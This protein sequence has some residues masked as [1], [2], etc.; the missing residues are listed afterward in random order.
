MPIYSPTGFLDITNATLR[1]SNTECQNLQIGSGNVYV[2]TDLTSNLVL[3]LENITNLGATTSNTVVFSNVTTGLTVSSNIV[4]TGNVTAGSFLGDGSGLTAV[5]AAQITGTLDAARIPALDTAKITTGTL[6]AAR[7]PA[8]DTAKITTGTLDAARIPALDT[9]KI[10]TGTLDAAR[11]PALDTAK[12]TTGTL[13]VARIPALDTAK[14]TTGTLD[15]ARIP[16]LDTAKITTGTLD[17]ARI[18]TLNQNTSGSAAT[19]TTA[20]TIG[21]VSFD[22]SAAIVP[23][24][25][26]TATFSGD[27]TVD[28][29]TFHV[30]STNNRVG[31]G[32]T[33]PVTPLEVSQPSGYF[34]SM[35]IQKYLGVGPELATSYVLLLK[36]ESSSPKRLAGK[37]QGVRGYSSINTAFEAEI[38]AGVGSGAAL[39][40]RMTLNYS[41]TTNSFYAKLVSLTYSSSTYIALALIPTANYNGMSGGI[42]FD[43]KTNAI[44]ELQ[45]ITD[46]ATLSNIVDFPISGGDKTTF[47]GNVGVGTVSP[48]YK[49]NILTDTN[50]D[51]ISLRDSTRELMK[52]AKGTDG[53]YINM[54]ESGVS[55]VNIAT[56]GDSYFIGGNVGIGTNAPAHKLHLHNDDEFVYHRWSTTA[57]GVTDIFDI[58]QWNSTR[59]NGD[60]GVMFINRAN[61][62]M[63]FITNNAERMRIKNDGDIGIGTDSPN[64]LLDILGPMDEGQHKL[65]L[66]D[67]NTNLTFRLGLKA[68]TSGYQNGWTTID[69]NGGG[70]LAI[71]DVVYVAGTLSVSSTKNFLIDHPLQPTTKKLIHT[72]VESPRVD[73]IY[74][75]TTQ[76]KDGRAIVNIDRQCVGDESCAMEDGTFEALCR[77]PVYYLQNT[78]DFNRLI[79]TID[80]NLLTIISEDVN[81]IAIVNWMVV[82]ERK[83]RDI[84]EATQTNDNGRLN[85]EIIDTSERVNRDGSARYSSA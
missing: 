54:F 24:T 5:P 80:K 59:S 51:G 10:T 52:I 17:A 4:A 62:D 32:T 15:A 70:G 12:I 36:S 85:T 11:I 56:G 77:D 58:A 21:G 60:H 67:S 13:D 42:Y 72:A 73:L 3:N 8:L 22:G 69:P 25:F 38:I 66:R 34:N 47:T 49:L 45:Y 19:L 71:Y 68:G 75:G 7:I 16:A 61:T 29:T 35:Y 31:I 48:A 6:D 81:S 43:G 83:D 64:G 18:P 50:Y 23:T 74:R 82:A 84:V 44:A 78:T 39:S 53:A 30:D 1:T 40:G 28:S 2:T 20:Q 55:K 37:I 57:G 46:L 14:I 9:A 26:T 79:G 33:S 63:R 76:L 27:V 65:R 41:G